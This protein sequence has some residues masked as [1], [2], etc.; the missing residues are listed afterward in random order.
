MGIREK[1]PLLGGSK[2]AW[3]WLQSYILVGSAPPKR[4]TDVRDA[5]VRL[6][7]LSSHVYHPYVTIISI[8]T[9]YYLLF[10]LFT[11]LLLLLSLLLLSLLIYY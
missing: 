10:I 5:S 1:R 6:L 8:A 4:A 11:L 7:T 9:I 2:V 3:K